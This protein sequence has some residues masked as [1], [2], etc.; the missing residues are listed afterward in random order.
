MESLHSPFP[1]TMNQTSEI[2]V[3]CV[4]IC[5][6]IS[7]SIP[8]R[9]LTLL[10]VCHL[11]HCPEMSP[12]TNV[13]MRVNQRWRSAPLTCTLAV[14]IR[15]RQIQWGFFLFF[16]LCSDERTLPAGKQ[17]LSCPASLC[18]RVWITEREE[19][20]TVM[21]YK[22]GDLVLKWCRNTDMEIISTGGFRTCRD[23]VSTRG[24]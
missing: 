12:V 8:P 13:S 10:L 23:Q 5:L 3:L 2:N 14:R 17:A 1:E 20:P 11:S 6:I 7:V 24:Q 15:G 21:H 19:F 22:M 16:L 9:G 4:F 18:G